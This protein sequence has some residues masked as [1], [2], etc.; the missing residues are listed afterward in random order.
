MST[1]TKSTETWHE[2]VAREHAEADTETARVWQWWQDVIVLVNTK[3]PG[4]TAKPINPDG[5]AGDTWSHVMRAVHTSG[6]TLQVHRWG[7]MLA[8]GKADAIAEW[9]RNPG[10]LSMVY[11]PRD[12]DLFKSGHDTHKAPKRAATR[13]AVWAAVYVQ[14][15]AEQ[16]QALAQDQQDDQDA[17]SVAIDLEECGLRK[18]GSV[19]LKAGASIDLHGMDGTQSKVRWVTVMPC[20]TGPK[21][22]VH[23]HN[24]TLA[25][26]RIVLELTGDF[27][28]AEKE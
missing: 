4:W 3:L 12:R 25:Q 28:A 22:I 16:L 10:D 26:A 13:I 15:Y 21:V 17:M 23:L 11:A 14:E 9:P 27:A 7:K 24:L 20:H 8:Q 19:Q 1:T 18:L 5:I 6:A 2:R